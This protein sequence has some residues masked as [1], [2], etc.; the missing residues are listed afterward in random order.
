MWLWFEIDDYLQ[1]TYPRIYA[2]QKV[3]CGS[4]KLGLL[5]PTTL[6]HLGVLP[7]PVHDEML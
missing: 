4:D 6:K 3:G 7:L 1:S 5:R 2:F